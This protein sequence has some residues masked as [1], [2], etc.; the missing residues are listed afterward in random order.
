MAQMA[1]RR[2]ISSKEEFLA[3]LPASPSRSR[4]G[5]ARPAGRLRGL[6]RGEE[7]LAETLRRKEEEFLADCADCAEEKNFSQRRKEE[8]FIA[9]TQN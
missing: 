3:D 6:R 5:R 9:R 4:F 8:E 7:F 2:I 1:Q